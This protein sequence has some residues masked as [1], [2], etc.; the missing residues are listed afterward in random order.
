MADADYDQSEPVSDAAMGGISNPDLS[1]KSLKAGKPALSGEF[2]AWSVFETLRDGQS[3]RNAINAQ[4]SDNCNGKAPYCAT[5]IS[6]WQS[7]FS[8]L[9][10]S[11]IIDKIVPTLVGYV[12]NTKYLTQSKLKDESPIGQAKTEKMRHCFTQAVRRWPGWRSFISALCQELILIG[13]TFA[14]RTDEYDWR[15]KHYRQDKAFVPEGTPQFAEFVQVLAVEQDIL[16]HELTEI[17]QDRESAE[18]A[19]WSVENTVESINRAMPLDESNATDN[20]QNPRKWVDIIQEGNVGLSHSKGAKAVR[21]GHVLAVETGDNGKVTH[22]VL[23]RDG[24]HKALLW[25]ESRFDSMRDVVTLFTLDPGNGNFYGSRGV[26]RRAVNYSVAMNGVI[27]DLVDQIRLQGLLVLQQDLAKGTPPPRI[28][29]PFLWLNKDST[30]VQQRQQL[31]TNIQSGV[32]LV[33]KLAEM[34]QIATQQYVPNTIA[35]DAGGSL[36]HPTAHQV[37]IDY[38]R[39]QQSVASFIGRFAGQLAEM[40]GMM[41][42]AMMNPETNDKEAKEVQAYL[43][44]DKKK[45]YPPIVT[46]EEL[47]EWAESPAA[48]VLVDLTIQE[49]QSKLAAAND[50][51]IMNSPFIDQTARLQMKLEAM[52]PQPTVESLLKPGVV[53]PN[54]EAENY[55]QQT[56]E[57]DAILQGGSMPVSGRD[58]HKV[59]L[60]VLLPDMIKGVKG[61]QQVVQKNP[62]AAAEQKVGEALD[63][64]HAG[65]THAEAHVQEWAKQA[66]P[67]QQIAP[68]AEAVKTGR[69]VLEQLAQRLMETRE[70]VL[71]HQEKQKQEQM[72]LQQQQ[73]M[74]QMQMMGGGEPQ[75]QQVPF[76]EKIATSWI[77]QYDKLPDAERRRL[78]TLTGLSTPA[79]AA[80]DAV[81][82]H[83]KKQRELAGAVPPDDGPLSPD[84]AAVAPPR[85]E[86]EQQEGE[87]QSASPATKPTKSKKKKSTEPG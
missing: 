44:G 18:A 86:P 3:E 48:E 56:M 8:T 74:E 1:P 16:I 24:E 20:Q 46:K 87:E 69:Q 13:Y 22:V 81:S 51:E 2:Q 4:I 14:I 85:E 45:G 5:D 29:R 60:D 7:N 50:P 28:K 37:S 32:Q 76:S 64:F 11:G 17:I 84:S 62:Q 9:F 19:K 38:Q 61:L 41:Q 57:T 40:I 23:D 82:E 58:N 80:L 53:D 21:L 27:N 26:G 65:M 43:L 33:N 54:E 79:L 59:H 36:D 15:P 73:A 68:Y 35:D 30:L 52:L 49:N 72:Q 67:K 31:A 75:A 39:E 47:K 25:H 12:E 10:L 42:R 6:P 83:Q 66:P 70:K 77:G 71:E 55:R 63:H 34:A 78:E